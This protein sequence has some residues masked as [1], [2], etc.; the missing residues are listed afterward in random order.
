[1][2]DFGLCDRTCALHDLATAIERNRRMAGH[3]ATPGTTGAPGP[4]GCDAG[5]ICLAAPLNARQMRALAA[6]LP[7]VHAEFALAELDYFTA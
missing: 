4:A 3:P 5:W 2:L 6:L 1:V 7:L